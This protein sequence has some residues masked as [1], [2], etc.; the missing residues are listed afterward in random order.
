M[1]IDCIDIEGETNTLSER[2]YARKPTLVAL[3]GSLRLHV[4]TVG[5]KKFIC[6][7]AADELMEKVACP[8]DLE[9]WKTFSSIYLS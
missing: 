1:L 8:S 4:P 6:Y 5:N 3:E 9:V 7:S 2:H